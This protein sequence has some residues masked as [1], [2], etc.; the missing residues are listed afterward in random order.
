M[1]YIMY[2]T[3]MIIYCEYT[4]TTIAI[5][6][7]KIDDIKSQL[8]ELVRNGRKVEFDDDKRHVRERMEPLDKIENDIIKY[9]KNS[10][11][12]SKQGVVD[13]VDYARMTIYRAIER[14]ENYG[15]IVVELDKK[16]KRKHRLSISDKSL[17]SSVMNDIESFKKAYFNL[18]RI[19]SKCYK[20]MDNKELYSQTIS[21]NLISILK[22]LIT[23]YSLYAVFEW[24][25]IIRDSEGLNRLYLTIFQSLNEIFAELSSSIPFHLKETD[26]K[27]EFLKRDLMSLYGEFEIYEHM[28]T[29]FHRYGL[30]MEFD[31]VMSNLF[32]ASKMPRDWGDIR[33]GM[34]EQ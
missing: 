26:K 3:D 17:I 20:K 13:N 31:T 5:E 2:I 15:I 22:H 10:S 4:M 6:S 29:E 18:I 32:M 27:I 7:Q 23:S 9:V 25:N 1:I 11:G 33:A 8:E 19:A 24:S 28:I 21:D 34:E 16:N 14:L 30:D 12:T